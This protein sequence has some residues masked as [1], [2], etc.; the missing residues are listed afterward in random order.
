MQRLP[1]YGTGGRAG[2]D[3][4]DGIELLPGRG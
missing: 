2:D 4:C 1:R 3:A